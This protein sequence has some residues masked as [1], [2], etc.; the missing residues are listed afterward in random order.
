MKHTVGF[1]NSDH[2]T[3]KAEPGAKRYP[4][5]G[6]SL[7]CSDLLVNLD[8]TSRP[9]GIPIGVIL[10]RN[11]RLCDLRAADICGRCHGEQSFRGVRLCS[12]TAKG[13]PQFTQ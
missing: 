10:R 9:T 11:Q 3:G 1:A 7:A 5:A 2:L 12:L 4:S 8:L 13:L 6:K